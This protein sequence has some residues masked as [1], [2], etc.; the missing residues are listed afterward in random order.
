M[1]R[2]PLGTDAAGKR[3]SRQLGRPALPSD[4]TA[5]TSSDGP[6]VVGPAPADLHDVDWANAPASGA[7]CGVPGL[8]RFDTKGEARA[9][10]P[11]RGPVRIRSGTE[12]LY[13]DTRDEAVVYV[14][15]DDNGRTQNTQ[16]AAGYVGYGHAGKNLVVIGSITPRQKGGTS[17]TALAG[18]ELAPGRIIVHEKCYRPIDPHCCPTGDA[19]TV[20]TCEGNGL[21]TGDPRI[22]S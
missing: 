10:S 12:V 9:T 15:C 19:T 21:I 6:E 16:I 11:V 5:T 14:G 7:F 18:A 4:A 17:P 3:M 8:M 13:G 22:T 2:W 20:W 1:W